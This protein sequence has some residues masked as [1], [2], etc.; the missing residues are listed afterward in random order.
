MPM[1]N[2]LKVLVVDDDFMIARLHAKYIDAQSHYKVLDTAYTGEET[3]HLLKQN[4]PDLLVLD[5]YL[6]D[7]SGL[8]V[9]SEIRSQK[10]PCDV[11]LITAAKE[12][13]VVEEGFRLGIFDY[14]MKPFNLERLGESL[15]KYAQYKKRLSMS[16]SVDQKVVDH[17]KQIRA[18][19]VQKHEGESGIDRRTL[20]RIGRALEQAG[21]ACTAEEV[22]ELAGVSRSTARTYLDYLVEKQIAAEA[23]SYGTVGR[24]RRLFRIVEYRL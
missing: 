10:I 19:G 15:Q 9:L 4:P 2:V 23:L 22:A 16:L 1:T 21:R 8:D 11:I 20:D 14:L 6:P 24:P 13:E 7:K 17:L 3:L 5:V 18:T 12:L